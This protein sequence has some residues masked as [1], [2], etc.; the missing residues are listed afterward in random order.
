MN[1]KIYLSALVLPAVFSACT[2]EDIVSLDD[3][4]LQNR[5]VLEEVTFADNQE[6][7]LSF[8][9]ED[10]VFNAIT[11]KSGD[12]VGAYLIDT[13]NDIMTD[14]ALAAFMSSNNDFEVET[15]LM[16]GY[17]LSTTI[18]GSHKFVYDETT[19]WSTLD[20][21][22]EGNYIYV[23][24][25]Q[26][27]KTREAI[28]VSLPQIQ[29]LKY[30][31]GTTELDE[32]SLMNQIVESG[33][34]LAVG[35][36]FL[37]RYNSEVSGALKQ[38]YAYP[39]ITFTNDYEENVTIQKVVIK[40]EAGFNLE[41]T[42]NI[43][44]V[45]GE[46][47]RLD[48]DPKAN[49]LKNS[50]V[51]GS[52]TKAVSGNYYN[53]KDGNY[54]ADVIDYPEDGDAKEDFIVVVAPNNLTLADGESF[55][56]QAVVPANAY[57]AEDL[58]VDVYTDKGI[59]QA[60]M[61][62]VNFDNGLRYSSENYENGSLKQNAAGDKNGVG[63]F[64][65]GYDMAVSGG[66][67]ANVSPVVVVDTD[68][69]LAV[70]K[71]TKAHATGVKMI[72]VAPM[73]DVVINEAIVN[74]LGNKKGLKV[75]Q[76]IEIEGLTNG[77]LVKNIDFGENTATVTEGEVS[78]YGSTI[79]KLAIEA[80]A[81]VI[82]DANFTTEADILNEGTLSIN[83]TNSYS[84][85]VTKTLG[86]VANLSTLNISTPLVAQTVYNGC[87]SEDPV[88]AGVVT[89]ATINAN[90]G[91]E[92][93]VVNYGALNVKKSIT[94]TS[95]ANRKILN[96]TQT[97]SKS[98]VVTV[99][100]SKVLNTSGT[101]D[102][103]ITVDGE[104][105]AVENFTN[106]GTIN[107]NYVID[108][109]VGAELNNGAN[110][111]INVD[112]NAL[113]TS[114]NNNEGKIVIEDRE[115]E[116]SAV[117]DKGTI[118]FDA[119]EVSTFTV[120]ATDK[121]NTVQLSGTTKISVPEVKSEKEELV[122]DPAVLKIVNEMT[123]IAAANGKYTFVNFGDIAGFEVNN[124]VRA[125]IGSDIDV[126]ESLYVGTGA[127]LVISENIT[128]K[129]NKSEGLVVKGNFRNL[130]KFEAMCNQPTGN[131]SGRGI[132]SWGNANIAATEALQDAINDATDNSTIELAES[133]IVDT[134]LNVEKNVTI[135]LNG[136]TLE[137][138]T[139][140]ASE[141][142]IYTKSDTQLVLKG[143]GIIKTNNSNA[144]WASDS[145]QI[146]I[147]DGYYINSTIF[148][149]DSSTITVKGGYFEAAYD[150][151]AFG[152]QYTALNKR[153]GSGATINVECG[154]F[155]NFNPAKCTS[156]SP[157][158]VFVDVNNYQV[159]CYKDA[160]CTVLHKKDAEGVYPN[161]GTNY[162]YKVVKR[163]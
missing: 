154:V 109:Q 106:N 139:N 53:S 150:E 16:K 25:Y 107:N 3:N 117:G 157:Y 78:F 66:E 119:G 4:K 42:I 70:I 87:N 95:I 124:N 151:E 146:T 86:N 65:Q 64:T 128:V 98:G 112:K 62:D 10:G 163:K 137:R 18:N 148:A 32:L 44:N 104:L 88:Y 40:S 133:V 59:F 19:G 8:E 56:F 9:N 54:T 145:S 12:A 118:V 51:A 103:T 114:I 135:D 141:P 84:S 158:G 72:E 21:M 28:K 37:S 55:A 5:V 113:Y 24:P 46:L 67:I 57:A 142:V 7:R 22:V 108:N 29:Y 35:Y 160:A 120:L 134:Y 100:A 140:G 1:K 89:T 77:L 33:Q 13:P 15:E 63:A 131:F 136:K 116:I 123:F 102:G 38:I 50:T 74:A 92:A 162:W 101:N 69:L 80:G 90:A 2:Q 130:G 161:N 31:E 68:D 58:T 110:G 39:R 147:E 115:A 96:A 61:K 60:V 105:M 153:D 138:K 155:K 34:P 30:K 132:Y 152:G 93:K 73:N 6:S 26:D 111:T 143:N 79:A 85:P 45:A 125:T 47:K 129:F 20:Q 144:I 81:S 14:E 121:F 23:L 83:A 82:V 76:D 122:A 17:S 94:V 52:W 126:Y 97:A 159:D 149:D 11:L 156:E 127:E 75:T 27:K 49:D 91:I 71:G 99:D 36:E 41:G 48:S 43:E